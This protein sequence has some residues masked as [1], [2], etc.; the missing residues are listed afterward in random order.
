MTHDFHQ[1][2]RVVFGDDCA[3]CRE[4]SMT[5]DGLAALDSVNIAK[6]GALAAALQD[7]TLE[8]VSHAD[9]YAVEVL[10]SAARV[11]FASG[12]SVEVAR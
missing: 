9:L 8:G 10:R 5:V 2:P 1:A 6:L 11:V 3:E 12:I 7:G 4:R